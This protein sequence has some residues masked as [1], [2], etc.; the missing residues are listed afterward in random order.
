M[1]HGGGISPLYKWS[2]GP[3][4]ITGRGP[5]VYTPENWHADPKITQFKS[6]KSSEPS[7]SMTLGVHALSAGPP[8]RVP[9]AARFFSKG[10]PSVKVIPRPSAKTACSTSTDSSKRTGFFANCIGLVWTKPSGRVAVEAEGW[11]PTSVN[12]AHRFGIPAEL[13]KYILWTGL[14]DTRSV[15]QIRK[16]WSSSM[17]FLRFFKL[18]KFYPFERHCGASQ[19]DILWAQT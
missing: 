5:L 3:L 12:L 17:F 19:I 7:T 16:A 18:C 15:L 10:A 8:A 11:W 1:G 9:S 6:G 13:E 4:L 2:Y 14:Q